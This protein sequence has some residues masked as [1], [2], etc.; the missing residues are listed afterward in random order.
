MSVYPS[1]NC[2]GVMGVK[3][4][5]RPKLRATYFWYYGTPVDPPKCVSQVGAFVTLLI[6]MSAKNLG[7]NIATTYQH[8]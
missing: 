7:L 3:R 2:L 8:W 4:P 1:I 5:P 6:R